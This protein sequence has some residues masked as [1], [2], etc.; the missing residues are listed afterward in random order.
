MV[1]IHCIAHST[2]NMRMYAYV[3]T[4]AKQKARGRER[5]GRKGREK[6]RLGVQRQASTQ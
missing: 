4:F 6:V 5:D 2:E 3:R 1:T